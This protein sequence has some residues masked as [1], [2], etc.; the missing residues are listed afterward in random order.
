MVAHRSGAPPDSCAP[1]SDIAAFTTTGRSTQS[2]A[3]GDRTLFLDAVVAALTGKV[4][5][6]N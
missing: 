3:P 5:A 6:A 1:I 2:F 4:S